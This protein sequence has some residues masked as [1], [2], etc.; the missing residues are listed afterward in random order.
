[1]QNFECDFV[2]NSLHITDFKYQHKNIINPTSPVNNRIVI[3]IH[4]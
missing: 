1:M 3:K 2:S 4:I